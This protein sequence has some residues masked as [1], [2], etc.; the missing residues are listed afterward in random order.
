LEADTVTQAEID[1][2]TRQVDAA[3]ARGVRRWASGIMADLIAE[4]CG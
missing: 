3:I 4:V 1:E 2:L